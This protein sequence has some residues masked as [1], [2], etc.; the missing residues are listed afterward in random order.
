VGYFMRG[1]SV[2][3][4]LVAAA[5]A[6][7]R[8]QNASSAAQAP[9][10]QDDPGGDGGLSGITLQRPFVS[11]PPLFRSVLAERAT[12]PLRTLPGPVKR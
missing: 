7:S 4:I 3:G 2:F 10:V 8:S 9:V 11:D 1:T 6:C 5:P 12:S